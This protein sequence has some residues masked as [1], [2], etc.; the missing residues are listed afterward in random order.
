MALWQIEITMKVSKSETES[1]PA[2]W[3]W[4][5]MICTYDDDEIIKVKAIQ[6][7]EERSG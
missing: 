5:D 4:D 2:K 6:I 7:E 3:N 1:D